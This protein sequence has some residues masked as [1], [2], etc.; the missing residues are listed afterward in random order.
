MINRH[1]IYAS[2]I[3]N[4]EGG[5]SDH[6]ADRG[7]LTRMGITVKTLM[8]TL[9]VDRKTAK[10]RLM[11]LTRKDARDFLIGHYYVSGLPVGIDYAVFDAAVNMGLGTAVKM[12]QRTL[13]VG[14]KVDGIAGPQTLNAAR[15]YYSTRKLLRNYTVR[16]LVRYAMLQV[17]FRRGWFGR[18]IDVLLDARGLAMRVED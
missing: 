17:V 18:A 2:M 11:N 7:G 14:V 3:I 16:R 12:L 4:T 5:W 6:P 1:D 9:G 13:G 15:T 10:A 8:R